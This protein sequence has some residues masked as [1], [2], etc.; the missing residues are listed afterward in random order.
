MP[1][2]LDDLLLRLGSRARLIRHADLPGKIDSAQK[3]ADAVGCR[4]ERVAKTLVLCAQHQRTAGATPFRRYAAV[5]LALPDLADLDAVAASLSG[6]RPRLA[7]RGELRRLLGALPG[8]VSPFATG[9]IPVYVDVKLLAMDTVFVGGGQQGIDIEIA[10]RD[11][12]EATK[13]TVGSYSRGSPI[14]R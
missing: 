5:V 9:A 14:V 2:N 12:V 13:A 11:L 1:A 4:P 6:H 7:S 10:P 8:T 3:F